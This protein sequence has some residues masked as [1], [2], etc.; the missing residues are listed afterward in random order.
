M[1]THNPYYARS[2][3][4]TQLAKMR[5]DKIV[6]L[7]AGVYFN[8]YNILHLAGYCVS[9]KNCFLHAESFLNFV[10]L[11]AGSTVY[12]FFRVVFGHP[13]NTQVGKVPVLWH[14]WFLHRFLSD[15]PIFLGHI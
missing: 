8:F 3:Y 13:C 10:F 9:A 5:F 7:T 11:K 12:F 4:Q 14:E 1:R 15:I 6:D 2:E